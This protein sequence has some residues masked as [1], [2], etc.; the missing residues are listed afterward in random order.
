MKSV[1]NM[2]P[3]HTCYVEVFFLGR[4]RIF[5]KQLSLVEVVNDY[6][7]PGVIGMQRLLKDAP[8]RL[9]AA[10][11]VDPEGVVR[12]PEARRAAFCFKDLLEQWEARDGESPRCWELPQT[13]GE[14]LERF[15]EPY[16]RMRTVI[17]EALP[18]RA[19]IDRYDDERAVHIIEPPWS[20]QERDLYVALS[21]RLR[22]ARCQWVV[23]LP[24]ES[25][26]AALF[27]PLSKAIFLDEKWQN[28]CC[29]I[30][31]FMPASC[32]EMATN[33]CKRRQESK[34]LSLWTA[35]Q[36]EK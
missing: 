18:W 2:L 16:L 20:P 3:P 27:T 33:K 35:E 32:E 21:L 24:R 7:G 28:G 9:F 14:M 5:G 17:W 10:L 19:C 23:I 30:M 34:S 25:A 11:H 6:E 13:V 15:R 31:S 22:R 36:E 26:M 4:W 8:D 12:D 1:V 29:L